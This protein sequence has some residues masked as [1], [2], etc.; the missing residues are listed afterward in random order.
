LTSKFKVSGGGDGGSVTAASSSSSSTS[1]FAGQ[2]HHHHHHHH[3]QHHSS[4]SSSINIIIISFRRPA[5]NQNLIKKQKLKPCL[6]KS[7]A[8]FLVL[9]F[10]VSTI[11]QRRSFLCLYEA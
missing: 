8:L 6:F 4:S 3:H 5:K 10:P 11:R 9:E 7:A 1:T 2:H